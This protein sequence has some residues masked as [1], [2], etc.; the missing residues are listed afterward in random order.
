MLEKHMATKYFP[1]TLGKLL[2]YRAKNIYMFFI[3]GWAGL[4]VLICELCMPI[5]AHVSFLL[6]FLVRLSDFFL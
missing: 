6:F 2:I 5:F 4:C 1:K 3:S